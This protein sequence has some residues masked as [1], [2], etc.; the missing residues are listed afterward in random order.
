MEDC[1][2]VI[3][4]YCDCQT[5]GRLAQVSCTA[6]SYCQR[7]LALHFKEKSKRDPITYKCP[8]DK[9]LDFLLRERSIRAK[10]TGWYFYMAEYQG[11]YFSIYTGSERYV[12]SFVPKRKDKGRLRKY[13][14]YFYIE[15]HKGGQRGYDGGIS[16]EWYPT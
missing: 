11:Q 15:K 14:E 7:S 16:F 4:T 12:R 6:W 3:A 1:I 13:K 2:K 8:M 5:L 9:Y 10:E